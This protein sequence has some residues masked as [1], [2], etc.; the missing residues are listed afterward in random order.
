MKR[1]LAVFTALVLA[2][3]SFASCSKDPAIEDTSS[4]TQDTTGVEV[5]TST[6]VLDDETTE[7]A[8]YVYKRVV[9]IGVD[10]GGNFFMNAETPNIDRIFRDGSVTYTCTTSTPSISAQSWGAMIHGVT[11]EL[12]RL[13]NSIVEVTPY[14]PQ[15]PFPSMMR[16]LRENDPECTIA[17]FVKWNPI[18]VGIVEDGYDIY[19]ANEPTDDKLCDSVCEYLLAGN[20][21]K[22]LFVAFDDSDVVGHTSGYNRPAHLKQLEKNDEHIGRIFDIYEEKGWIDD[23]LFILTADHGGLGNSHGGTTPEELN[24]IYA[25]R[26]KTVEYRG[27][28]EDMQIR[29]NASVVL[30]ALGIE[31]PETWTSIVPNGIF[32][33]YVAKERPE[34]EIT[35]Q[36]AHRSHENSPTPAADSGKYIT[37][38]LGDRVISYIP[39]DGTIDDVVGGLTT[40]Q[41]DKLY[42]VEGYYGEGAS[43]D[44]GYITL[45]G[46]E[47]G[48]NSFSISLWFKTGGISGEVPDPCLVSN[49]N[50]LSGTNPGFNLSIRNS[51]DV[52]FNVGNGSS[53]MDKEYVFPLDYE[54]GWV[55]VILSVDREANKVSFCYDF[56]ELQSTEIPNELKASSF[57]GYNYLNIGCD[58]SGNYGKPSLVM[59]DVIII[60][61]ALTQDDVNSL[62]A[63]YGVEK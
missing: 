24:V 60:D 31:Q 20:D 48:R 17:S 43:F 6:P 26:G 47:P 46:Y 45:T 1:L 25:V 9:C 59:D 36:Y 33:G 8:P 14:D 61:G 49:S 27:S 4:D 50:W 21:P 56:G 57:D 10:G 32:E 28:A 12:H 11:P 13:T 55:H 18:N 62:A 63:Y 23:T 54:D 58:G 30:Y 52:K 16:V 42:F 40:K 53:R 29:D 38:V 22:L 3:G 15:S 44:D 35:F 7:E 41:K 2:L 37:D 39:L 19:K 51:D 34:Y 5:D